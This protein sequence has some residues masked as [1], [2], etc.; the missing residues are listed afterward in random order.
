MIRGIFGFLFFDY[1]KSLLVPDTSAEALPLTLLVARIARA[2][3]ADD[4]VPF[5]DLAELASA[6]DRRSDFHAF[7]PFR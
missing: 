1:F 6:L 7:H 4:A 2:N 5:D 3:D